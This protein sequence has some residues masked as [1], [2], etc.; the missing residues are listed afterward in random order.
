MIHNME[1]FSA[2]MKNRLFIVFITT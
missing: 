1:K 2:L